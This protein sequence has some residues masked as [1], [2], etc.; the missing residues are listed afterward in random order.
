MQAD[1]ILEVPPGT[2]AEK[3]IRKL[4]DNGGVFRGTL[5]LCS[6]INA[7]TRTAMFT[8]SLLRERG[9]IRSRRT[10][11]GYGKKSTHRLVTSIHSHGGRRAR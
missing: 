11:G 6:G 1:M 2:I 9:V 5:A 7:D 8:L 10:K 4:E 3:I